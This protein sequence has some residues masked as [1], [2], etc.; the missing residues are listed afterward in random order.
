M[1]DL[2]KSRGSGIFSFGPENC[3]SSKLLAT[4]DTHTSSA[5]LYPMGR[6]CE[7][8]EPEAFLLL[9]VSTY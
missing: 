9:S 4:G 7:G 6:M 5:Q 2:E 3:Y 1:A 8:V